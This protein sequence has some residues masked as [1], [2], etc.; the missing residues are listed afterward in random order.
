MHGV[1]LF[2]FSRDI[3]RYEGTVLYDERNLADSEIAKRTFMR[4]DE[5]VAGGFTGLRKIA[6]IAESRHQRIIPHNFTSPIVTACHIQLAACTPNWDL[7]GY[8]REQRSPWTDVSDRINTLRDGY[9]EI[10]DSPG[11]GMTLNLEY[12]AQTVWTKQVGRVEQAFPDTCVGTDS[13]TTMVNGLSVLGWGVGGIEAE[14]VMLGQP[15]YLLTPQV[16][17]FKIT[18]KLRDG[19]TATDLVLTVTQMLRKKGVVDKFVEF[20]GPG[21]SAMSLPDR[22]TIANM[23]P[24]YGATVGFFPVDAET[25][26]YWIARHAEETGSPRGNWILDNFEALLPKFVKVFPHEYKRVLGVA[27]MEASNRG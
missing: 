3:G 5:Q 13:H 6:A 22:A 25:L 8:V 23:A 12:L 18:G 10:P 20:Y 9:L 24:E 1:P 11:I 4:I 27:R 26:R 16:V 7:Q 15:L 14:A 2:V 21:L 19:V 17:G